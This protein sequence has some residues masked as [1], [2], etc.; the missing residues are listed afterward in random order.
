MGTL[1]HPQWDNSV[2]FT[3]GRDHHGWWVVSDRLGQVGGLFATE[4]AAMH[5]A[6]GEADHDT[7]KICRAP[8]G[9][10]LELFDEH[11]TASMPIGRRVLAHN[12]RL[13]RA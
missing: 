7:R 3:I 6:F 4:D 9:E 13:R 5:F 1:H 11:D 8:A 10:D 12:Q 2:R